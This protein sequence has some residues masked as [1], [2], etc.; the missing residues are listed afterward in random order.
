MAKQMDIGDLVRATVKFKTV[1]GAF[2]DPTTIVLRIKLP[3]ETVTTYTYL[4]SVD[5]VRESMG[6][7]YVDYLVAE[8]GIHY[9][10]WTGTGAVYA[11]EES[12]FV[13]VSTQF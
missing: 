6:I 8:S 3:S 2:V 10:K 4:V 9:F 1:A 7:Y 5:V 12:S 13:V 11:A